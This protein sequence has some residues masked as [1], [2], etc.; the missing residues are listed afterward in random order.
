MTVKQYV[1]CWKGFDSSIFWFHK[2]AVG[3]I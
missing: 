2:T 1:K 3:I